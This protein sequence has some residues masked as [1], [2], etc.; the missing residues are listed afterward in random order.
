MNVQTATMPWSKEACRCVKI[1]AVSGAMMDLGGLFI[2]TL[3]K[4]QMNFTAK[5]IVTGV[6]SNILILCFTTAGLTF[7][8]KTK[9]HPR[10]DFSSST[11]LYP[12]SK[13]LIGRIQA[14]TAIGVLAGAVFLLTINLPPV[15]LRLDM[16]SKAIAN[17]SGSISTTFFTTVFLAM[18]AY[19]RKHHR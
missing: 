6:G 10:E 8:Y 11:A 16:T 13:K 9:H 5:A 4:K 7:L 2:G 18:S 12:Y 1:A 17:I 14:G 19:L 15:T 3:Y